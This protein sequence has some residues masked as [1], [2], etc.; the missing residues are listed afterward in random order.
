MPASLLYASGYAIAI[1]EAVIG[2]LL[3]LGVFLRSNLIAGAL[4]MIA[5]LRGTCL[6]Q[7]W[8]TAAIRM[9]YL[10]FWGIKIK[11]WG[12]V[13]RHRGGLHKNL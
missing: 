13:T 3:I 4:L 9:I 1:G 7:D 10:A 8:D 12:W 6:I 2:M 11:K 5:L